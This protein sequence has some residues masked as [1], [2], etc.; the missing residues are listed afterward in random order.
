MRIDSPSAALN[1]PVGQ[2]GNGLNVG[3]TLSGTVIAT[4]PQGQP[5]AQTPHATIALDTTAKI[6]EGARIVFKVESAPTPPTIPDSAKLG[7]LPLGDTPLQSKTWPNLDEA[8]QVLAQADP[9]RAQH[10]AQTAM[11]QP[12]NKLTAQMLFFLSA[13][14]GGDVKAWM[15]ESTTRILERERPGLT[16]RLSGD[17]QIMSK[18]AD[19]PQSGDWRLAL[20]PLLNNGQIEQLRMY[21][22]GKGGQDEKDKE[23]DEARFV[24][25]LDLSNIGH[26]QIDGLM[27][28]SSK[29]LD[30]IIR[31][32]EPL[33][34]PW[35]T[36]IIDIFTAGQDITGIS[37]GLAFQA[38]P[39]NFIEFPPPTDLTARPGLF[40]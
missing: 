7:R 26:L 19:E 31:S 37:G 14:K 11:P 20:I 12:G 38:A 25:D 39:G 13:L 32:E 18:M 34:A 24:L 28:T 15:G 22:R 4:T 21:Y 8:M 2:L 23:A 33:P 17:F 16:S 40:V 5:I 3:S 9:S 30:L 35:R 29:K 1:A 6:A 36:D 10:L 27:K